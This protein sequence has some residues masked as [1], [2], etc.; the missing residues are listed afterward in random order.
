MDYSSIGLTV[1][2]D[3]ITPEEEAAIMSHIKKGEKFNTKHRNSISR[4]GSKEPYASNMVSKQI[5]DF[6]DE[7]S[8]KLVVN[9]LV[10]VKPN[11]VTINEYYE[12]QGIIPHVDSAQSGDVISVLSLVGPAVMVFGRKEESFEVDFPPRMLLQIRDEIR[13]KWWHSIPI[14]SENRY[15]IV[16]RCSPAKQL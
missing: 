12:G 11:S 14:V 3:F 4:Y 10:N 13:W 15:S 6:L 16:F 8:D 1:I 7:L 9:G 5:P 2:H